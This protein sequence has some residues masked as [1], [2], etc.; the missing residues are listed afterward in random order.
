MSSP[1]PIPP[2]CPIFQSRGMYLLRMSFFAPQAKIL[3]FSE[4]LCHFLNEKSSKNNTCLKKK[5]H[6]HSI[7]HNN[8]KTYLRDFEPPQAKKSD[9]GKFLWKTL[10][11]ELQKW[12]ILKSNDI[13]KFPPPRSL[14]GNFG[15]R[16]WYCNTGALTDNVKRNKEKN[17]RKTANWW[18]LMY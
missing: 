2:G 15:Q 6:N 5:V 7:S 4:W 3:G 13:L 8:I 16:T 14:P 10:I 17:V 9:L 18:Y 1:L 11:F 12:Y